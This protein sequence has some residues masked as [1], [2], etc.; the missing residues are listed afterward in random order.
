[1]SLFILNFIRGK[2]IKCCPDRPGRSRMRTVTRPPHILSSLLRTMMTAPQLSLVP[3]PMEPPAPPPMPA[4]TMWTTEHTPGDTEPSDGTLT[5]PSSWDLDT[6]GG[7]KPLPPHMGRL[8]P[9]MAL[10]SPLM[11]LPS[12]RMEPPPPPTGGGDKSVH[13]SWRMNSKSSPPGLLRLPEEGY[14]RKRIWIQRLMQLMEQ[15]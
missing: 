15:R 5:T 9:L 1:M 12:P 14:K 13:L 2:Q 3:P 8:S 10:P 4:L 6:G 7:D 11:M